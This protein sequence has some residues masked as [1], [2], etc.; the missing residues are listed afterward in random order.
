MKEATIM[1]HT[2]RARTAV[3]LLGLALFAV[4]CGTGTTSTVPSSAAS[5]QP[6]PSATV[7]TTP[8][9][10]VAPTAVTLLNDFLVSGWHAPMYAG[11][12]KGF[13]ADQGLKVTIEPGQG[14]VDGATKVAAGAADFA[15]IDAVSAMNAM[16]NGGDL[17]L[18]GV[19]DQAFPGGLCYLPDRTTINGFGD[20]M[21]LRIGS[22]EGDAY[23]VP[24]PG[25]IEKAGF[26]PNGFDHII[27]TPANYTAALFTDQIDAYACSRA[28]FI[29]GQ[30]AATAEGLELA[31]FR[32]A[33]T[34]FQPIGHTLVV[35]GA[36]VRDNPDLVQRFVDAWAYSAVWAWANPD[37][38][39]DLFLDANPAIDPDIARA[40]FL[41]REKSYAAGDEFF[42]FNEEKVNA[43]VEFLNS[44]YDTDLKP[45]DVY[46][47]QF[48]NALPDAIKH[49]QLP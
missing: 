4:A 42:T 12:A 11:V 49:G 17:L 23:M 38:T 21:G 46:D 18:V 19:I 25:L 26:D 14:S 35:N 34:G 10:S 30:A 6:A 7:A 43:T 9:P 24:L 13:F 48:V 22:S 33:D 2:V 41:D 27:M 39:M 3:A 20:L 47:P 5:E 32:Y 31:M 29:P 28:T 37:E 15:Q 40:A 16:A 36:L 8:A 1:T 45:A 44:A